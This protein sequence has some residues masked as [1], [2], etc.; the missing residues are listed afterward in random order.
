MLQK[1][2]LDVIDEDLGGRV[3]LTRHHRVR[4]TTDLIQG[5]LVTV[6]LCITHLPD[7]LVL[8]LS[9]DSII[10]EVHLH[11]QGLRRLAKSN[12]FFIVAVSLLLIVS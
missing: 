11:C 2:L 7:N 3:W 6:D 10:E 12:Y 5:Q 4:Q 1:L 9:P 8:K